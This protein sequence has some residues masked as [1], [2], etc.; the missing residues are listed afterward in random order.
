M[1]LDKVKAARRAK[2]GTALGVRDLIEFDLGDYPLHLEQ[3]DKFRLV[4]IIRRVRPS[5]MLSHSAFDPNADHMYATRVALEALIVAKA[6]P[7]RDGPRRAAGFRILSRDRKSDPRA[8][9]GDTADLP[10]SLISILPPPLLDHPVVEN[11]CIA[12]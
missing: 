12:I 5:F 4:D 9:A 6:K 1:T 10:V 7:R 2:A 11:T 8:A 3:D